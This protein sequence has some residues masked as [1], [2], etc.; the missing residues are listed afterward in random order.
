MC[1]SAMTALNGRGAAVYGAVQS[2]LGDLYSVWAGVSSETSVCPPKISK[3]SAPTN[4]NNTARDTYA[5]TFTADPQWST[6]NTFFAVKCL[7]TR[8]GNDQ[9]YL[10]SGAQVWQAS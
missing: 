7:R 9:C 6:F 3:T 5:A 10:L 2:P 4:F 8:F 1:C